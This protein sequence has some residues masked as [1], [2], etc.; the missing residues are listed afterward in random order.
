MG[1]LKVKYNPSDCE[2]TRYEIRFHPSENTA[3]DRAETYR[4]TFPKCLDFILKQLNSQSVVPHMP[5]FSL[6][7]EGELP[8]E[9]RSILNGV[10]EIYN[11]TPN[12]Y[13]TLR[14]RAEK[15]EAEDLERKKMKFNFDRVLRQA[16]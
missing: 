8:Q 13:S 11:K 14:K 2:A 4:S 7:I 10:V 3:V 6:Q 5:E 16:H 15:L 12:L 1:L 9:E